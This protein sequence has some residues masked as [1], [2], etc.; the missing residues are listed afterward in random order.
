MSSASNTRLQNVLFALLSFVIATGLWYLVVGRDHVETQM[1]VRV[2]Y[3]ALPEGLVMREGIVNHLSVRL[4]GSAELL[5]NLHSRD[6]VYTVDLSG[7]KR[8]AN[9]VP[10]HLN[11]IPDFKAFEILEVMPSRLVLEVDALTE[12]VVPLEAHMLPLSADSPYLI[13]NVVLEPSV[14]TIKGP[15]AQVNPLERLTVVYDPT[16][17]TNEGLHEAN[18]AIMAPPQVEITP[19]VTTLRYTMELKTTD[20]ELQRDIQFDEDLGTVEVSPARATVSLAVPENLVEDKDYLDSIHIVARPNSSLSPGIPVEA[21]L[22]VML[23]SGARLNSVTPASAHLILKA[24]KKDSWRPAD[25][26]FAIPMSSFGMQLSK[27]DL[28]VDFSI[29]NLNLPS[30]AI[31]QPDDLK[32]QPMTPVGK[33]SGIKAD[34]SILA[35]SI[36]APSAAVQQTLPITGQ[37]APRDVSKETVQQKVSTVQEAPAS[38]HVLKTIPESISEQP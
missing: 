5:R 25:S 14:V 18:V 21:P 16:K 29:E 10:L 20:I 8:G 22:I 28:P 9:A 13:S 15:E 12:R 34:T 11:D 6:I 36:P 23:P 19:P 3:R 1:S 30:T 17:N 2:E 7:V 26:P 32:I 35:P 27:R 38:Q 24:E 4:R 31:P 37:Q 33:D